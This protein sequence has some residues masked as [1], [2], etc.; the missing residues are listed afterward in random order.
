M[1]NRL[2]VPTDGNPILQQDQLLVLY[3]ELLASEAIPCEC[4]STPCDLVYWLR[5]IP[6]V[7]QV[8]FLGK[9]NNANIFS[10]GTNVSKQRFE[11]KRKGRTTFLLR[12]VNVTEEDAGVYAC[13]LRDRKAREVWKSGI[14]LL[15]GGWWGG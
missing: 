9:Q 13:V 12:I 14:L 3:P 15:P 2:S 1:W 11:F 4:G 10:H 6:A 8:Q 5:T 7:G